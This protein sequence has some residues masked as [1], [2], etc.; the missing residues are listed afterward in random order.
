MN[1]I[2]L[3]LSCIL[4]VSCSSTKPEHLG[5][6]NQEGRFAPCPDKP[7][8]V[9]TFADKDNKKHFIQPITYQGEAEKVFNQLVTSL[10]QQGASKIEAR[11]PYLHAEFTSLV[12]RFVDD[13][14][15]YVDEDN[16]VIHIK[17][18][19]RLGYYDFGVNRD[20]VLYLKE[21]FR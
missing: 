6:D 18:A 11:Y 9:S 1:K 20:R 2:I 4:L 16:Q 10:K 17:S 5:W 13:L 3:I 14:E 21:S 8:C 19:A 7:N 12:F 15:S